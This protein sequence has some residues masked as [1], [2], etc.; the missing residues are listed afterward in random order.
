MV[1]DFIELTEE[2]AGEKSLLKKKVNEFKG[3][4]KFQI[5]PIE[6]EEELYF[7]MRSIVESVSIEGS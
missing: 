5:I 2:Y 1:F 6:N 3:A 7:I 4:V